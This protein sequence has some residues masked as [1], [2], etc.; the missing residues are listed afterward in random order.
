VRNEY[1]QPNG[2]LN[3]A[4]DCG[5]PVTFF[6]SWLPEKAYIVLSQTPG[7]FIWTGT[8]ANVPAN[9]PP[10]GEPY[11]VRVGDPFLRDYQ[12]AGATADRLRVG[13]QILAK[14]LDY[15]TENERGLIYIDAQGAGHSPF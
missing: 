3:T 6:A 11:V 10:A 5:G 15:G 1:R 4:S 14:F 13:G 8:A 9:F 2:F 7:T 12:T